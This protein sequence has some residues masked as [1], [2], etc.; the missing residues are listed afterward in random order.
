M[1]KIN[2]LAFLVIY[3][4]LSFSVMADINS[5]LIAYYPFDGNIEDA[6]GNAHHG[7][8]VGN[9]NFTDGKIE[10]AV[11]FNSV[12]NSFDDY[13]DAYVTVPYA[14]DLN[15][16]DLSISV[17]IYNEKDQKAPKLTLL[18]QILGLYEPVVTELENGG[19]VM[20]GFTGYIYG[21]TYFS[22]SHSGNKYAFDITS[23][24]VEGEMIVYP[25]NEPRVKAGKWYH[26]VYTYNNVSG[27]VRVYYNGKQGIGATFKGGKAL[28][29]DPAKAVFQM[30]YP[31]VK[32]ISR[33]YLGSE[34]TERD[35]TDL[36]FE[37][38]LDD[39]RLYNRVLTATDIKALYEMGKAVKH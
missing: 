37:G 10:Q 38:R 7:S 5:G 32:E 4:S 12:F 29:N 14:D 2:H 28:V 15:P 11:R 20:N 39:L 16:D 22:P 27:K 30:G 31:A 33:E 34:V 23:D 6:S 36:Q 19:T 3:S 25:S 26:I 17:W 18:A 35:I 13:T 9:V 8:S 21:L 1:R 24:T